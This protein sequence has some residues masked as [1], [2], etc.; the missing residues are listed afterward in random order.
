MRGCR[1]PFDPKEINVANTDE[2]LEQF[3][4]GQ[5]IIQQAIIDVYASLNLTLTADRIEWSC[6]MPA[7][8]ISPERAD[9][10][11][12][13]EGAPVMTISFAREHI[14]DCHSGLDSMGAR[15]TLRGLEERL[16][17]MMSGKT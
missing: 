8:R 9:A 15:T 6:G 2:Q 11:M 14:E 5:K 7:T 1:Y 17:H 16:K 3:R 4:S 10:R 12:S 13:A